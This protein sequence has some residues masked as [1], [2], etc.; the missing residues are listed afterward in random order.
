[1]LIEVCSI[2]VSAARGQSGSDVGVSDEEYEIYAAAIKQYY[3]RPDTK[4]LVIEDRTFRYDFG[5]SEEPWKDKYKGL[6]IDR[7]TVEDYEARNVR[8]SL[9][10]KTS[11]KLPV[12]FNLISDLDLKAIFHGT[13]GE[14]EWIAYYRRFSDSSG[15]IMLSRIGFNTERTQAL[16]YLGSR[17][18]PGC[19]DIHFLLLEKTNGT[20]TTKKEL[21]KR[22]MG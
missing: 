4:L 14:L 12:K 18:G 19:G 2:S 13:W 11:F 7:S 6:T 20:W 22:N 17:C 8:P 5:D 3:V 21:K 16:L 15:F 10:S 1:M 9:L